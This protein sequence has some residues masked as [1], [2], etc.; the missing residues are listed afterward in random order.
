M[1]IDRDLYQLLQVDPAAEQVVVQAAFKRLAFKYHP[2]KNPSADAH[3]RMQELNDAYAIISDPARRAAYDRQRQITLAAQRHAEDEAR[4]RADAEHRAE[5]ARQR[6]EQMAAQRRA[7]NQRREAEQA[8]SAERR[9]EY[10]RRIRE[11]MAA[12]RRAKHE[13]QQREWAEQQA[14]EAARDIAAEQ[15]STPIE[16]VVHESPTPI[17]PQVWIEIE[18]T[19]IG[20]PCLSESERQQL[21]LKQS[22]Q[23]LQ[24]EIFKLDYGITDAVER[25]KYWRRRRIPWA[26]SLQSGQSTPFILGSV[27]TF[28]AFVLAGLGFWLGSGYRWVASCCLIGACTG[29]WTWRTCISVVPIESFVTAWTEAKTARELQLQHL[30]EELAQLEAAM[31]ADPSNEFI[32]ESP[33]A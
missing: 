3:Q 29:W 18:Q 24:N 28:I 1:D 25:L 9:A 14:R 22:R 30:K 5:L 26:I 27:V 33:N 16:T 11:Q 2:D 7:D 10:E 8:A 20:V 12:Q 32:H 23:A 4:Q 21:A 13:R 31:Q 6:K 15:I 19:P 17:E